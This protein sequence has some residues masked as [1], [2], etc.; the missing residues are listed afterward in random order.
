MRT[1]SVSE[2]TLTLSIVLLLYG[3]QLAAGNE[4]VCKVKLSHDIYVPSNN[5]SCQEDISD[6]KSFIIERYRPAKKSCASEFDTTGIL[7]LVIALIIITVA[8]KISFPRKCVKRTIRTAEII[9]SLL[10]LRSS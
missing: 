2:K 6:N 7:S 10:L 8:I 9:L 4:G 5:L 3:D 1:R